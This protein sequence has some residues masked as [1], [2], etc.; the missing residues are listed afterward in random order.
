LPCHA[1][2]KDNSDRL[3]SY[4]KVFPDVATAAYDKSSIHHRTRLSDRGGVSVLDD[5]T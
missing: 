4:T 3:T 2:K 1:I 5:V